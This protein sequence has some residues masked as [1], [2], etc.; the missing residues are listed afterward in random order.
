MSKQLKI[1]MCHLLSALIT[2][3]CGIIF[4]YFLGYGLEVSHK[5]LHFAIS[6]GAVIIM[7]TSLISVEKIEDNIYKKEG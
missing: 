2:V 5:I 6:A 1:L 3:V 7:F 4:I